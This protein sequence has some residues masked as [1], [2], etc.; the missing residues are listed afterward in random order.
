M[1]DVPRRRAG[2]QGGGPGGRPVPVGGRRAD[3]GGPGPGGRDDGAEPEHRAAPA[4]RSS[5]STGPRRPPGCAPRT[6][7]LGGLRGGPRGH[8]VDRGGQAGR[9]G[10]P[11]RRRPP[12]R[13]AGQRAARPL[14]RPGSP[15]GRAGRRH[16][17]P[18]HR[19]PARPG[20]LRPPGGG[21]HPRRLPLAGGPA[22]GPAGVPASTGSWCS[23]GW[24]ED[25]GWS[26]PRSGRSASAPTRMAVSRRGKEA[27]TRY[28]RRG[29]VHPPGAG[30]PDD[31][32]PGDRAGPTRSGS[33]SRPSA[34]RW[35]GT[36]PT[37]AGGPC[38]GPSLT[39]PVP[40]RRLAGLRPPGDRRTGCPGARR[41]PT[42]SRP[43][44]T[45]S[46]GAERGPPSGAGGPGRRGQA[47][48]WAASSIS[49]SAEDLEGLGLGLAHLAHPD[50]EP[51]GRG[52]Q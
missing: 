7:P 35:W 37:A 39:R 14:S 43:A 18:G 28:R 32:P 6:G 22:A 25:P 49:L 21:P 26:T 20:H 50:A 44:A 42:T 16:R 27:R 11:S 51:L 8:R 36:R 10:G 12:G 15:A 40:P 41:S 24:T 45:G 23:G 48:S 1:P 9:A 5:R 2:G 3:R 19:A 4:A 47:A 33:T 13:H 34:T 31:G 46:V 38:P 52:L 29:A 17:P 30:H